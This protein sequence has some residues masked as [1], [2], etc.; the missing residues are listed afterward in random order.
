MLLFPGLLLLVVP[1]L[2][3]Y[4]RWGR[5]SGIGGIVR[6]TALVGLVL[7]ASVPLARIGGKGVDVVIVVDL[8][9]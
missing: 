8:S 6:V 4:F 3:I 7:L 9:R 2:V 5:S 1:L